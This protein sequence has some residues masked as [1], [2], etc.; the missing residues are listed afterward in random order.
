MRRV[1]DARGRASISGLRPARRDGEA[2]D[3]VAASAAWVPAGSA[4]RHRTRGCPRAREGPAAAVCQRRRVRRCVGRSRGTGRDTHAGHDAVHR[5]APVCQRESRP[6]ERVP[7]RRHQRR[8]DRRS[9]QDC[10][11]ARRVTHVRLCIEGQVAR[12]ARGR[13]A[14]GDIRRAGGHGAESGRS[15]AYHRTADLDRRWAAPLVAALRPEAARCLRDSGRNRRDDRQY[16]PRDDVRRRVRARP[17]A[18][19]RRHPGLRPLSQRPVCEEYAHKAL[20]LDETVPS[21]HASLAWSLFVYDWDWDGADREF[22]RAIELNPRYASAHQWYAFLLASRGEH[23]AALLEGHTALE[24]DPASVSARRG[25][26]WLAF[27]A[28]RFD[29]AL[30]HLARAIEMN[31]MA[32]ESYRILGTTLGIQGQWGEAERVLRDALALPGAGAYTQATLGWVLASADKRAQA[33]QQLRELETVARTG[34]VSPVAFA[35]VHVGLGNVDRALD[36]A[37]RAYDE[38]RGWL[39]YFKVNPML[40]PLRANAR[41]QTLL[42]KMRL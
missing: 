37:E 20:Q 12:C 23:D 41:F 17:A 38:R 11:P 28:R 39:A 29:Q 6:R 31:P 21:A 9:R 2:G 30:D 1:R 42:K 40:D 3:R 18:L 16:A 8:V 7:E 24:L 34:Y 27:Y 4:G 26:G 19:H 5:R 15:L 35:I 14:A 10:R 36:W 32:V 13:R 25:V 33:E 22:R